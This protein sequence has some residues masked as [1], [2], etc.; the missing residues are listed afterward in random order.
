MSLR[1]LGFVIGRFNRWLRER[2]EHLP[3]PLSAW[4]SRCPN[5]GQCRYHG[6]PCA[7]HAH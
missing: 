3:C 7:I 6:K 5:C 4:C 2:I 1:R